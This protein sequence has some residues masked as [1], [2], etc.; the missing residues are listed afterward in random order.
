MEKEKWQVAEVELVYR[1]KVKSS[2]L[3]KVNRSADAYEAL[4]KRWNMDRIELQEQFKILLLNRGNKVIGMHEVA[5][6]STT[7]VMVDCKYIFA[8]AILAN[9]SGIIL[10]HNHPSG[11]LKASEEDRMI[12]RRLVELGK[13]LEIQIL[14]HL[15]LTA[16]GYYSLAD[17]GLM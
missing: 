3:M 8:A 4:V 11:S 5:S 16:E 9:A 10:A 12:T 17:E 7:G 2:E 6:G 15:I 1:S 14:D 13:M